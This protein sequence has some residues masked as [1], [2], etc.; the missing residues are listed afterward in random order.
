MNLNIELD[1]GTTLQDLFDALTVETLKA[2]LSDCLDTILLI[3]ETGKPDNDTAAQDFKDNFD[4]AVAAI[5]LLRYYTTD[6]YEVESE[7][8][9]QA[10]KSFNTME[11]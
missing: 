5:Q 3:V 10:H 7:E 11:R 6:S 1:L 8:L 2:T 4:I 9:T